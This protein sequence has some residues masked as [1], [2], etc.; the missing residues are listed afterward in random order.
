MIRTENRPPMVFTDRDAQLI[1]WLSRF[2]Y[3]TTPILC[4]RFQAPYHTMRWRISRL[5]AW[6]LLREERC[7]RPWIVLPTADGLAVAGDPL[8][9][10]SFS[11]VRVRHTLGIAELGCEAE[12]AGS[13]VWAEREIRALDRGRRRLTLSVHLPWKDNTGRPA[14]HVPDLVIAH[15][16]PSGGAPLLEAVELELTAKAGLRL[17]HILSAYAASPLFSRVTYYTPSRRLTVAIEDAAASISL[18]ARQ[19][20][21]VRPYSGGDY[22]NV[23]LTRGV[24]DILDAR[25]A[26][27]TPQG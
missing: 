24:T 19:L 20:V 6:G 25:G 3:A 23:E 12:L 8:S 11:I 2:G 26:T 27:R 22:G 4:R 7:H 5:T 15:P 13:H 10:P 16:A 18:H 17:K 9:V 1:S 21:K 14:W